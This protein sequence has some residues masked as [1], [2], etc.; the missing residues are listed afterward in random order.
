IDH[1]FSNHITR[2]RTDKTKLV[3]YFLM[4]LFLKYKEQA[5]FRSICNTHVGQ[6]GISKNELLRLKIIC[7]PLIE[8]Q[9]IASILSYVD[10]LINQTQKIV[11]QTQRLKKGILEKLL[12]KGIGHTRFNKT[13][14]GEIPEEWKIEKLENIC[15]ITDTP[16]YTSPLFK[17]GIPVITTADCDESGRI[18]YTHVN[19]TTREEYQKRRET[20]NPE[21][22][23]VLFTR[24]APLG[25]AVVVDRDEIAVGQR[26]ILLKLDKKLINNMFLITFLNSARGIYQSN[27]FA[28]KTTVERVNISDI[29]KFVI[30][31]PSILEQQKISNILSN[32]DLQ[33]QK[34]QEYKSNLE[35][36]KKGLMQKLL[37]GQIRVKV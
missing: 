23:D 10:Y 27:S 14:L 8:Q 22:D 36:L 33:I 31:L 25:I 5:I 1:T 26:I 17:D 9:K 18:D 35:T 4:L 13:K 2:I 3:P 19:F 21:K 28:I 11:E 16:H 12:T 37:T 15:K 34:E 6:S 29:K 32:V 20:I 24:E 30:P 7:P